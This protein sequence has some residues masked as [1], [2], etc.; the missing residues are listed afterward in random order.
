MLQLGRES[1]VRK[2]RTFFVDTIFLMS[3]KI[4]LIIYMKLCGGEIHE[5]CETITNDHT[6][7]S[8]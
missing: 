3:T 8:G 2:E 7:A 6:V 1:I 4:L 5:L